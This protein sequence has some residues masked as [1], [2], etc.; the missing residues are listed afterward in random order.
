[1]AWHV[2]I[3]RP[4]GRTEGPF[5]EEEILD[6]LDE[7]KASR[8]DWVW[9]AGRDRPVQLG[10]LFRTIPAAEIPSP[11][12]GVDKGS[13]PAAAALFPDLAQASPPAESHPDPV[14]EAESGDHDGDDDGGGTEDEEEEGGEE[15]GSTDGDDRERLIWV[16]NPS[17]WNYWPALAVAVV[18]LVG[19]WA[20]GTIS[21]V[22]VIIGFSVGLLFLIWVLV[23]RASTRYYLTSHRI[24]CRSGL[25]WK[26][27]RTLY[28]EDMVGAKV[29]PGR[30]LTALL[31]VG[32][33]VGSAASGSD[34]D[35][36]FSGIANAW[37]VKQ[38][39]DRLQHR[40]S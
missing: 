1:M 13:P 22:L 40:L 23:D 11:A 21:P 2:T 19:G 5:S 31:G 32:S 36:A 10:E 39:L 27:A 6:M 35:V 14:D 4:G 30:G 15:E 25:I 26:T 12:A 16:G 17:F 37:R 3:L 18:S 8:L 7:G 34:D 33:V 9:A 29:L 38:W 28:L 24:E 20:G